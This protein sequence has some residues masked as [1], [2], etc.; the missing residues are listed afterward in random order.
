M[1][2]ASTSLRLSETLRRHGQR[3]KRDAKSLA[4]GFSIQRV[5]VTTRIAVIT[6]GTAMR[7]QIGQFSECRV[8]AQNTG[9][10]Q[11]YSARL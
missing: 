3:S 6:T 4:T 11:M 5:V 2:G 7:S 1:G 10:C 8:T 9:K